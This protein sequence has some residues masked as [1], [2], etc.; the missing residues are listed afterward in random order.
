M[1]SL[2][3]VDVEHQHRERL[4]LVRGPGQRVVG[5]G[6][7]APRVG[8]RRQ[9]IG[10]GGLV[11]ALV[12]QRVLDGRRDDLG[13]ALED[14]ALILG[15]GAAPLVVGGER[16][17]GQVVDAQRADQHFDHAPASAAA[18]RRRA[19]PARRPAAP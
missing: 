2:K 13:D 14:A 15:V 19:A 11:R 10:E 1:T 12:A 9:P 18:G 7:E 3:L 4:L 16:A 8:Q 5:A 17:V 6:D